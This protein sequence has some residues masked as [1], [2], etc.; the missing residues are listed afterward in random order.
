M[1]MKRTLLLLTVGAALLACPTFIHAQDSTNAPASGGPPEGGP[2][3]HHH[4][5]PDVSF[6]TDAQKAELKKAHDAALA[7]NP[8]LAKQDQAMQAA[9][10][11]GTPPTDE[12]REQ[13]HQFRKEM[14]AAMIKADP[15]VAPIL[16]EM[17]EHMHHHGG[18]G[19]PPPESSG[20]TPPSGT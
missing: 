19:G 15:N 4:G 14:D 17:K 18:P 7:A 2:G 1:N 11:A 6:L 12:Q 10:E 9:H 16:A 5:P 13:F 3:G 8:D 20:T